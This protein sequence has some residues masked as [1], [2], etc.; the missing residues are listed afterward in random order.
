MFQVA[1]EPGSPGPL[2]IPNLDPEIEAAIRT[3]NYTFPASFLS[4]S[5]AQTTCVRAQLCHARAPGGDCG[6][7][8]E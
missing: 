1:R 2:D 8:A 6:G 7:A 3:V 5:E 4:A